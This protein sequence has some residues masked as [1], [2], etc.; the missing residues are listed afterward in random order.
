MQWVW[1]PGTRAARVSAETRSGGMG[2]IG[3][4]REGTKKRPITRER[5]PEG[6]D[7]QVRQ[8]LEVLSAQEINK[9]TTNMVG[10]MP[11]T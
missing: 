5:G 8:I 11:G 6:V 3:R 9:H 2:K 10:T 7:N 4:G 1:V